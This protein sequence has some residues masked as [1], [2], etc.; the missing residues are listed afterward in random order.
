MPGFG[1]RATELAE[2][3]KLLAAAGVPDGFEETVTTV[4]AFQ[5]DLLNDVFVG[6]L[7]EIGI[8]LKTENI[9]NDFSVFLQREI[10]GEYNLASTL[11]LSGPYPDAQLVIYHHTA[12]GSRNYGKYGS[13]ELD[14]KL[15][16]Q[17]TL[18]D[19]K[20]RQ[21]LV[22]EIQRDIINNPGPAWAGS[23]IGFGVA[24]S[25]LQN[26]KA[27]PFAAGYNPAENYWFK[28]A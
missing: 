21:A 2:A 8:K 1:P 24:S 12:K 4:T 16:K 6:N 28:R 23:R 17:S 13:P 19:V 18:Y 10:R 5:A 3:K 22:F 25:A 26:V 20:A 15:D 14:A 27:T 9:G 11:F 7:A